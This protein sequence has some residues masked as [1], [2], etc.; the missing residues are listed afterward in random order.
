MRIKGLIVLCIVALM[1]FSYTTPEETVYNL[2]Q[3]ITVGEV[4]NGHVKVL[5]NEKA[6]LKAAN[7]EMTLTPKHHVDA[8]KILKNEAVPGG[9][10][11]IEM[12]SSKNSFKLVRA[13]YNRNN[14]LVMDKEAS[15]NDYLL[16]SYFV[17]CNGYGCSPA[18]VYED[19]Q[20]YWICESSTENSS[21]ERSVSIIN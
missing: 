5:I 21:C 9:L 17:S 13:L 7:D 6:F 14:K 18:L 8:L 10:Y 15:D 1:A 19:E 16:H 3:K 20:A 4:K 11:Y 12:S 2:S